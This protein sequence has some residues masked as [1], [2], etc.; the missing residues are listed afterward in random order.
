M[1]SGDL[2]ILNRVIGKDSFSTVDKYTI[3]G[4]ELTTSD[5][6]YLNNLSNLLG[7]FLKKNFKLN[8]NKNNFENLVLNMYAGF[9]TNKSN[10]NGGG[11]KSGEKPFK[12]VPR[13]VQ[14]N[15][16][17]TARRIA[18]MKMV[19]YERQEQSS[20]N[21]EMESYGPTGM[22]KKR[23]N[24]SKKSGFITGMC[25]NMNSYDIRVIGVFVVACILIYLGYTSLDETTTE[26]MGKDII[27]VTKEILVDNSIYQV[28]STIINMITERVSEQVNEL[29]N[30]ARADITTNV[31]ATCSTN[32]GI[33]NTLFTTNSY[34]ACV[35][36]QTSTELAK[37]AADQTYYMTT[38]LTKTL[39]GV[40][41]GL[42][43]LYIGLGLFGSSSGYIAVR[44]GIK[45]MPGMINSG[46]LQDLRIQEVDGGNKKSKKHTKNTKKS[47]N[48]KKSKNTKK[49]RK[50][51]SIRKTR[52]H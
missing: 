34:T 48:T 40:S 18:Q 37:I 25:N 30:T 9:K 1:S 19:P 44:L 15:K 28:P 29:F 32:A 21:M 49:S 31:A 3:K 35:Q 47:R 11:S 43:L 22:T 16:S 23:S 2:K 12:M 13:S 10:T 6:E 5:A 20:D 51:K 52:K 14:L 24:I 39:A 45:K 4:L 8:L 33:V 38:T 41:S 27:T 50:S 42:N 26:I 7:T 17:A 36:A 46:R